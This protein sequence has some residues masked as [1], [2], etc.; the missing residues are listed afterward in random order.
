MKKA[1]TK[2]E[3]LGWRKYKPNKMVY[4]YTECFYQKIFKMKDESASVEIT[5]YAKDETLKWDKKSWELHVYIPEE[6]SIT[7]LT[8]RITNYTYSK[9]N[10]REMERDALKI[11]KGLVKNL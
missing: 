7:G 6:I 8:L 1:L 4:E 9:L 10:F 2:Y 5:Q 11:M 3:K